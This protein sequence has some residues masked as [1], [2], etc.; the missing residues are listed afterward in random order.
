MKEFYQHYAGLYP[1]G[2]ASRTG[3]L[4]EVDDVKQSDGKLTTADGQ[5]LTEPL[6]FKSTE[7]EPET[8][9]MDRNRLVRR[10]K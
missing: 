3:D 10:G 6:A 7:P 4:Y 2:Q 8:V 5:A 9:A 1:D